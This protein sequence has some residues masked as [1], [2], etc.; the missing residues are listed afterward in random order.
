[1]RVK[2]IGVIG[3]SGLYEIEGLS[4]IEQRKLDTP[5]GAP[6]DE[7][8]IGRLGQARLAFLPRHGRGHRIAPHEINFRAN[9][10]GMKQLGAEWII[11]VSA[12]GSM[13]EDILPGDM[14]IVD[15]FFDR[16]KNRPSTF[17]G[18]GVVGHIAFA[19]PVCGPLAAIV[20]TASE[21][22]GARTHRGGTY[23]CIEGPQFSTR[24][25]SLT[26]R[27]WGVAV[28][29]MTNLT[30]AKLAREAE[31]CYSTLA[32]AT[33]FDCWHE[34]EAAVTADAVVEI[35]RKNVAT[36]KSIIR[37]AAGRIP[38]KRSCG[39]VQ[40]AKNAILTDRAAIP[41]ETRRRLELLFGKYL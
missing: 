37:E 22:V 19:D 39:C 12:V 20:A 2:T 29:G 38:D 1:M 11:S 9:I 14:V 4:E 6:S 5:F 40:A 8:V 41:A 7:Y 34:S 24:A 18:D 36:A 13:R 30:E 23:L 32:L 25:E 3:G 26:Y 35:L 16:T 17:F 15:Q 10:F 21:K 27:K 33:D 28:I 31:I